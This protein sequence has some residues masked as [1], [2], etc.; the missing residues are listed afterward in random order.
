M[1]HK[2]CAF[3]FAVCG[4]SHY[5]DTLNFSLVPLLKRTKYPVIVVTDLTRNSGEINCEKIIHIETPK[6][7]N[8]HQ[9]SIFLKTSLHK[10]LPEDYSYCYLD[11]DILAIGNNVD[12]IFNDFITPIQFALDHCKMNVFSPNAINC[13]CEEQ[14]KIHQNRLQ[15][16]TS[17][18]EKSDNPKVNI[19]RD[20]FEKYQINVR[21][22]IFLRLKYFLMFLLP[23]KV[24]N[25]N[26][27][28]YYHRSEKKWK[29]ASGLTFARK[30]IFSKI[31]KDAGYQWDK[32]NK[33]PR[34]KDGTSL[35]M[36]E[37]N[38]LKDEILKKFSVKISNPTF[39]HY[40]GGVFLFNNKSHEFLDFWHK[41]TLEIFN[42]SRWKTRDQ[43]TLIAST[44]KFGIQN[45]KTLN[46]RWN[47]IVDYNNDDI[48]YL[49]VL[50]KNDF[51]NGI[52][53]LH[54]YHHFRD[55]DWAVW[56]SIEKIL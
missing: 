16:L 51:T 36:L 55:K 47:F 17:E 15:F 41:S 29:D 44:W 20:E 3:V 34:L 42:D 4:N 37:C 28:F 2:K 10:I 39:S 53:F 5:I 33:E 1:S 52:Q 22:S 49:D 19:L 24:I 27:K 14:L 6:N 48:N 12:L 18:F 9:A 25:I 45:N 46:Q 30:Y 43:G 54:V 50:K 32:K 23:L 40:N 11:S 56:N 31:V 8:N 26:Y 7:F 35:K 38:H 21:E 13:N